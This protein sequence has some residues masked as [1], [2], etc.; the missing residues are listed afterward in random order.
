[1]S[2]TSLRTRLCFYWGLGTFNLSWSF[3]SSFILLVG[4]FFGSFAW[5]GFILF[6]NRRCK[7]AHSKGKG[8]GQRNP[9]SWG[10]LSLLP[11]AGAL[12]VTHVGRS[13]DT[14]K[15]MAKRNSAAVDLGPSEGGRGW[16]RAGQN[17][18]PFHLTNQTNCFLDIL[19]WKWTLPPEAWSPL[20][21]PQGMAGLSHLCLSL[22]GRH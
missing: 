17:M 10:P 13:H 16:E 21:N 8:S 18:W 14:A 15:T 22:P 20:A 3:D 1:M 11:G 6:V 4:E 9:R 7:K 5:C 2:N 19:G 12:C